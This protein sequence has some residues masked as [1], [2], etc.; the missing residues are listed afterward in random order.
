MKILIFSGTTEGRRLS[1]MLSE[2]GIRHFVCVAS[3]YGSEVM[4][5]DSLAAIR[6][7]KMNENEMEDYLKLGE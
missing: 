6:I 3:E 4:S 5:T 1:E 7:G 2:A